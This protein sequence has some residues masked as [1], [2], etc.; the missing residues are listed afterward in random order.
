MLTAFVL[1]SP[2]AQ[3]PA[4]NTAPPP[5]ARPRPADA[6]ALFARLGAVTG[7]EA[8]FEEQKHLALLAVPLQSKGRLYFHRP[9]PKG[10]GWLVR[11]VTAPEPQSVRITPRELRLENRDGVEVIDLARSDKVRTFV[12]SLVHVFAGDEAALRKSYDVVYAPV[13]DDA[14]AWTLQL[15]PRA[16]P[17]DKLLRQLR[18]VGRGEA[19]ERI[20]VLEPNGDRTVTRITTANPDRRFDAAEK[21]KLFGIDE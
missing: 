20:E 9:D 12:Q 8:T 3:E 18:L 11:E 7:L 15:T 1:S 21:R 5:A 6:A 4:P 19:V 2:A 14:A 13:P 16:A 10:P 17:L